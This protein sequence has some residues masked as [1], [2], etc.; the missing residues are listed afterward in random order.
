MK[1]LL[2]LSGVVLAFLCFFGC[3]EEK[4]VNDV[5]A[6]KPFSNGE[7]LELVGIRGDSKV[8]VRLNNGFIVEGEED[9]VLMFDFFGTFCKPCKD[10]A[11]NISKLAAKNQADF[12]FIGLDHFESVDD[13][14]L[15]EWA[16]NY[17]ASYFISNSPQNQRLI[18]QILKDIKYPNMELLPF[19]VALADGEYKLLSNNLEKDGKKQRFYL[20]AVSA[21][22]IQSDLDGILADW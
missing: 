3:T 21:E 20:G 12:V 17:G 5:D 15:L 13:A 14:S 11:P 18:A 10:E 6:F 1:F 16:Q 9:K 22:M 19:K 8:I 4:A 7:K 2:A